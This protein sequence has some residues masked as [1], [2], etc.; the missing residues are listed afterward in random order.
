MKVVDAVDIMSSRRSNY[1]SK[2][3]AKKAMKYCR[4]NPVI[5]LIYCNLLEKGL[6]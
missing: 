1:H 3:K 4:V 2:S 5:P 6:L